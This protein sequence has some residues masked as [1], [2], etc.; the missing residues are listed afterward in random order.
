MQIDNTTEVRVEDLKSYAFL[1]FEEAVGDIRSLMDGVR[2]ARA[3]YA[4][5]KQDTVA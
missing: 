2:T 4:Q 3:E 5:A 1:W